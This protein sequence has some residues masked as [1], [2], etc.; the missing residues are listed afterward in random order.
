VQSGLRTST[1]DVPNG[2]ALPTYAVVNLSVVQK[3]A[4]RT[5]L[6]LDVL[7]LT[8]AVYEIRDDRGVGVDAPQF[9]LRRTILAGI[10]QLL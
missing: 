3:A 2:A 5:E 7:N 6:R 10:L 9:K 1:A 4:T 8:D